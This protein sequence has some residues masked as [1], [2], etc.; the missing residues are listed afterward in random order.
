MDTNVSCIFF[1]CATK[2]VIDHGFY[3]LNIDKVKIL[4]GYF[5][6]SVPQLMKT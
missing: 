6:V 5:E 2:Q 3:I 1:I 4:V